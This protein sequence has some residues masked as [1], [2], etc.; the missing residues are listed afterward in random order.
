M[1]DIIYQLKKKTLIPE[2]KKEESE[3]KLKDEYIKTK[4]YLSKNLKKEGDEYLKSNQFPKAI[5][6]YIKVVIMVKDLKKKRLTRVKT[7]ELEKEILIPSNLNKIYIDIKNKNWNEEIRHCVKV[8]YVDPDNIKS[9]YRKCLALINQGELEKAEEE[10]I[11]LEDKIGEN[12]E[13]E[14]LII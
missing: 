12:P 11:Y 2:S 5:N 13:L 9:R 4:I 14:E 1:E 7:R 8:L 10:L 6:K 3:D